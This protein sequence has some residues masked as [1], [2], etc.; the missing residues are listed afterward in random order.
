ML[1]IGAIGYCR[2]TGQIP[3]PLLNALIG[4]I[5]L[6]P[7]FQIGLYATHVP[8][9]RELTLGHGGIVFVGSRRAGKV[10]A[11]LPDARMSR[12]EK[13]ITIARDLDVPT[14]VAFHDGALYVA[15]VSRI[16]RYDNIEGRL[17]DPPAP[18]V[19]TSG[20]PSETEHGS[21]FIGF[22]PDGWLY[23]SVGVPCNV[24][25]PKDSRYGTILRMQPD[26]TDME[27]FARGIRNSVGFDWQPQTKELWFTDNG[28][29]GMGD[30]IPPDELDHAPHAGMNF[31]FPYCHGT[32]VPDPVFGQKRGCS[33]FEPPAV[34]LPA[35]V[36]A[37]G[38]RF[39]TGGS[40]PKAFDNRVF[41]AEH[42]SWN[43]S[44]PTGDR[45][46]VIDAETG[47][48]RPFAEGWQMG[49]FR[50]GRPV[51][52]LVMP[53]GALLVSDDYAGAIYRISYERK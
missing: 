50:W 44:V 34:D 49:R 13:V 52:V 27:V 43:R 22:G 16:L 53:D 10:Y 40:F 12:A 31:G 20:L 24:C 23:V 18:V 14:G 39:Y 45:I 25:E 11:L 8:N 17:N 2:W 46:S 7:K 3:R 21:R 36:A 30:N 4:R 29:D 48:Y 47:K 9:A 32:D 37:L 26:G 5:R 19:V 1:L 33:E 35:H 42:G 51:D 28:R 41:I 15:A 6:P 38:M